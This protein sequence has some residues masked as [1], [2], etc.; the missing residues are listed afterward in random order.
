MSFSRGEEEEEK[1]DH[2]LDMVKVNEGQKM[3]KL[4]ESKLL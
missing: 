2:K 1:K 4:V 3:V